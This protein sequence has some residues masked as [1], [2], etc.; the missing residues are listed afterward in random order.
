[1]TPPF[2]VHTTPHFDRLLKK[3][4]KRHPDLIDRYAE[5]IEILK[6]DPQNRTRAHNIVKLEGIRPGEGQYREVWV[7]QCGL[8]REETYR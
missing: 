8:R 5:A 7:F 6:A 4:A 1:M 2:S 3:L